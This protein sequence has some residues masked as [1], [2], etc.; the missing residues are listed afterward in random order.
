MSVFTWPVRVYWEDTDASGVV[1]HANY[2][3]WLER[4]RT[5]WLRSLG[6]DQEAIRTRLAIAFT[7]ARLELRYL[8]PARLDDAL[9][10]EVSLVEARRASLTVDQR[11][12]RTGVDNEVLT[13]ARVRL[14]CVDVATF[15]PRSMPELGL[16]VRE[17]RPAD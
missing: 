17:A 3:R 1:Y 5:E 7:I 2:L 16:P 10:V 13:E 14:G 11:V 12:L 15:R 8:R 6:H 4:A 9:L